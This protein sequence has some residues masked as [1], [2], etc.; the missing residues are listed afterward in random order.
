MELLELPIQQ[1]C[2]LEEKEEKKKKKK[3][4]QKQNKEK[5][6][7]KTKKAIS[8]SESQTEACSDNFLFNSRLSSS[9]AANKLQQV[10]KA[11]WKSGKDAERNLQNHQNKYGHWIDN[12]TGSE[13]TPA[14][15][16][17]IKEQKQE[18]EK[19]KKREREKKDHETTSFVCSIQ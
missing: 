19:E 3:K 2:A 12:D 4:K 14:E 15:H 13:T 8:R 10:Q 1:Q 5:S 16:R 6:M 18:K 9:F 7:Q 17:R 11:L